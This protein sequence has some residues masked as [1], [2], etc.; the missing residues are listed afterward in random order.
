MAASV[1]SLCTLWRNVIP[2][3]QGCAIWSYNLCFA[4][5]CVSGDRDTS[6][7]TEGVQRIFLNEWN[8][9]GRRGENGCDQNFLWTKLCCLLPG[10]WQW[11]TNW[12]ERTTW[13]PVNFWES[14]LMLGKKNMPV[15]I[16]APVFL[17]PKSDVSPK[18]QNPGWKI[19]RK[20][21]K[22]VK[23]KSCQKLYKRS[24]LTCG[25][26]NLKWYRNW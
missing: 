15:G 8:P 1:L 26:G 11:K 18:V 13:Y 19:K 6:R 10:L 5:R 23:W 9:K 12:G 7:Q 14:L 4:P 24:K 25:G 22:Y 20:T 21:E 2:Q 16:S 17:W 3:Q